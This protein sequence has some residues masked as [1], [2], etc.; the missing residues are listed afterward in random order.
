MFR[1]LFSTTGITLIAVLTLVILI[2]LGTYSAMNVVNASALEEFRTSQLQ[3]VTSLSQQV[4]ATINSLEGDIASLS[5]RSE[6][7]S[8]STTRQDSAITVLEG[9]VNEFPEGVIRS[10]T[11]FDFRGDP[12]YAYPNELNDEIA[13]LEDRADYIYV[14]PEELIAMTGQGQR[15]TSDISIGLYNVPHRDLAAT[16]VLLIAPVDS[17]NLNTE[18]IAYEIDLEAIF[19][20]LFGFVDLDTDGQLWVLNS[21]GEVLYSAR[22]RPTI[23]TVREQ[24][25]IE[26]LRTLTE[27]ENETYTSGTETREAALSDTQILGENFIL[28]LSR[29]RNAAQESVSTTLTAIPVFGVLAMISVIGLG[30]TFLTRINR[31]TAARRSE[32]Q[33]RLTMR[34]L[35][36]VSRALNSTLDLPTV[37]QRI[38]TELDRL[39]PHDSA[40]ILLIEDQEL[41]SAASTE[42]EQTVLQI[43]EA[44]AA[45]E[46]I[47]RGYSVVI[48][49][50]QTDERWSPATSGKA[51]LIASWLGVPLRVR[52][53]LVGV[54]N[55]NSHEKN[56]FTQDDVELAE[57]FADQA[58]IAL[59]NARLHELEVKAIE[60][61]LTIARGIQTSLLPDEAPEMPQLSVVSSSLPAR[62]VSGDYF[63]YLPLLDDKLGIAIGDVQGKG[64]PAALMMAVITTAMRDEAIANQKPADLLMA[65]NMRLLDR[66]KR[67]SM[68]SALI[69]AVF[70]P[71]KYEIEI[72]NA[73]M[74]QPY[75]RPAG[76]KEFDFVPVGG[77]PIGV[78]G[79]IKYSS[80]TLPFTPGSMIVMFSDGVVEAQ[81]NTGEFFGFERVEALLNSFGEDVTAEEVMN[82]ILSDVKAHLGELDPQDDT[83]ILV[84]KAQGETVEVAAPPAPAE[85]ATGSVLDKFAGMS[86]DEIEAMLIAKVEQAMMLATIEE[87]Q[88]ES[89]ER[90]EQAMSISEPIIEVSTSERDKNSGEPW[91]NVELFLPSQLGFEKIARSTVEA[92]AQEMGFNEAQIEDMKTAVTEACMNAIEHGNMEDITRS[93]SVLLSATS[94]KLEV[95]VSDSG[96]RN[97]SNVL[98]APGQGDMRGW[99]LFFMKNLVDQ[100]EIKR[101]PEGGNLVFMSSYMRSEDDGNPAEE[102]K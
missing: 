2:G 56:R 9:K 48:N 61:E 49:D 86:E 42:E 1:R 90:V 83:T 35:L 18:F 11:R 81:N 41:R 59:Q 27:P 10:I 87:E 57:T 63:S 65:L 73:G 50:T 24:F 99:G 58:S 77:Y 5:V 82:R 76:K 19:A 102:K 31:E 85:E 3:L 54:L 40:S 93:V 80:K 74:V 64:I 33:R 69:L 20:D 53:E 44:R 21:Q 52:E 101:L 26:E 51:A 100:L 25:P 92:L 13:M 32:T 16:T 89:S 43:D 29:N 88:A 15:V 23:D 71:N 46:V 17:A 55:V 4:Q 79:S 67:N 97:L 7:Q 39:V 96:K 78:S 75:I 47:A 98:P 14:L 62:Q 37:L 8:T 6:I 60:Q 30:G 34:S 94:N 22:S 38:L 68:N 70:D 12:R 91:R 66:M 72:S 45:R 95:R 84:L 36:E 28:F